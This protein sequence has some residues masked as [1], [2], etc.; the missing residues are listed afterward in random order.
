LLIEKQQAVT[1]VR[2]VA[3]VERAQG[4]DPRSSNLRVAY[5]ASE[6]TPG[7]EEARKGARA[8]LGVREPGS[9]S[10]QTRAVSDAALTALA[11]SPGLTRIRERLRTDLAGI[12]EQKRARFLAQIS[13]SVEEI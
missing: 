12:I 3:S 1:R 13:P 6:A 8:R 5:V 2:T 4:L 9:P 10:A 7:L 11:E